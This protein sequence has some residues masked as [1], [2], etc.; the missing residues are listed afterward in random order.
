MVAGL[1]VRENRYIQKV[2]S[3]HCVEGLNELHGTDECNIDKGTES[4]DR[5]RYSQ[6]HIEEESSSSNSYGVVVGMVKVY[7][8]IPDH[9]IG[10]PSAKQG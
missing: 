7:I 5:S 3:E 8:R 9:R 2:I 10:F 1:L 4:I 6:N